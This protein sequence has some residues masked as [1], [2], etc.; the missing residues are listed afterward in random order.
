MKL[1]SECISVA[2]DNPLDN[3]TACKIITLGSYGVGKSS[4]IRRFTMKTKDFV[5][6]RK[7]TVEP[8]TFDKN[9]KV[10]NVLVRLEIWDTAGQEKTNSLVPMYFRNALAAFIVFD[11]T[12]QVSQPSVL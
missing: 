1:S 9:V 3:A 12:K 10:G 2:N 7:V 4:I 5:L 6:D 11:V 8:A